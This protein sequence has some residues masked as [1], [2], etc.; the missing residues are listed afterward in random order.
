MW[1]FPPVKR[2][3]LTWLTFGDVTGEAWADFGDP[4]LLPAKSALALDPERPPARSRSA[5]NWAKGFANAAFANVGVPGAECV[6]VAL[7]L[8]W[9]M[10]PLPGSG[11]GDCARASGVRERKEG[12]RV[13]VNGRWGRAWV[14]D[15]EGLRRAVR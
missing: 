14:I 13:G 4:W 11:A 8:G 6:G 7:G 5:V 2:L 15:G 10:I 1:G 12:T 9:P 3:G